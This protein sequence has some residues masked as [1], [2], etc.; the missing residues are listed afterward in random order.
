MKVNL[1]RGACLYFVTALTLYAGP[2][3]LFTIGPDANGVPDVFTSIGPTSSLFTLGDGSLGFNGGLTFD[4]VSHNFYSIANDSQGN[5][6]L[7]SFTLA[8]PGTLT[9]IANIG[10]GFTSGLTLDSLNGSLYGI[11]NDFGNTGHSFFDQ[12]SSTSGAVNQVLDL[13]AGFDGL[14]TGGLTFDPGSG[15]F[16]TVSADGNGVSRQF[17]S[18]SLAGGGSV[19]PISLLGD[20]AQQFN[21][22]IY[23]N[24]ATGGIASIDTGSDG[25]SQ[26]GG[27]TTQ[28][29]VIL[30]NELPL[31]QGFQNGALTL[32]T[33][34]PSPT[35]PAGLMLAA[36]LGLCRLSKTTFSQG[37]LK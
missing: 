16:Y 5:S 19:V 37:E 35:I 32:A 9:L 36:I 18:I 25:N 34:E 2:A 8:G 17:D 24:P 27:I 15:L 14:F 10:T 26:L 22:G 21:G 6:F 1:L 4:P 29:N 7:Y 28:G 33:P 13:G 11:S 3:G 20:G 23:F 30:A 12:I 31:G